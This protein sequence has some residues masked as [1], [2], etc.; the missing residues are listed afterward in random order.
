MLVYKGIAALSDFRK[1]K[2]AARL[3]A[4]DPSVTA[5]AAEYIHFADASQAL[6]SGDTKRLAELVTY[7]SPF[8]DSGS[9]FGPR[10]PAAPPRNGLRVRLN[11]PRRLLR[12]AN[13]GRAMNPGNALGPGL[14]LAKTDPRCG[15]STR[16]GGR[17]SLSSSG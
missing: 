6:S 17:M 8:T 15:E 3:K 11:S 14:N 16:W 1:T 7:G 2:L 5:V 9:N 10:N 4:I 13:S 12:T